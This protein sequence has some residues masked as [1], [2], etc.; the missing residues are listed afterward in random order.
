MS[1]PTPGPLGQILK[2]QVV[3]SV[4]GVSDNIKSNFRHSFYILGQEVDVNGVTSPNSVST[5]RRWQACWVGKGGEGS[6]RPVTG[7][8]EDWRRQRWKVSWGR[9]G[10]VLSRLHTRV[11]DFLVCSCP[12]GWTWCGSSVTLTPPT[13]ST[14]F[15]TGPGTV[16]GPSKPQDPPYR[17]V[18]LRT[19]ASVCRAR[20]SSVHA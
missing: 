6:R 20:R 18:T 15:E 16:R 1:T 14:T 3:P 7:P 12:P 13:P 9:T 11:F 4:V 2:G 17:P 8:P 10:P 5:D 19:R